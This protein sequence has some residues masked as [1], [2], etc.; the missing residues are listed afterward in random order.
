M[1]SEY[2]LKAE[3]TL[4]VY[5]LSSLVSLDQAKHGVVNVGWQEAPNNP[6]SMGH[7]LYPC[8]Q[9]L[10][11][12]YNKVDVQFG[13]ANQAEMFAFARRVLPMIDYQA[14]SHLMHSVELPA[15]MHLDLFAEP[16]ALQKKINKAFCEPQ[17]IT[18]NGPLLFAK[19]VLFPWLNGKPFEILRAEEHG[20]NVQF[21]DYTATESAFASGVLF[22]ADLKNGVCQQL[23]QLL[24]QLQKDK[25]KIGALQAAAYPVKQKQVKE[26]KSKENAGGNSSNRP[27]EEELA[28]I[29]EAKA[30]QKKANAD[31]MKAKAKGGAKEQQKAPA[32]KETA[33]KASS[34]EHSI[35]NVDIRVGQIV[36]VWEV[37]G[38]DKLYGE[39][40][41]VGEAEPRRICSGLRHFYTL[42]QMKGRKILVIC[43]LKPRT[44]AGFKSHGMVFCA[45]SNDG[46]KVEFVDPPAACSPGDKVTFN[47][48]EG[49]VMSPAQ[50]NKFKVLEECFP[51]LKTNSAKEA[52]WKGVVFNTA[53]GACTVPTLADSLIS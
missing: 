6:C 15:D 26:K 29:R 33:K 8:L 28:K 48:V 41:D 24:G 27:S 7:L 11:E 46:Q 39:E 17:N 20:G 21:A 36:N 43:N 1:G 18:V 38:S 53:H 23:Q 37:E 2:Q 51:L 45:K 25:D 10:D 50:M 49:E 30:A 14:R 9:A 44:M 42:E 34:G 22:P 31:A 12:E 4:D 5:K 16:K 13:G 3:F 19:L 47:G 35:A 40:I 32:S 52:T